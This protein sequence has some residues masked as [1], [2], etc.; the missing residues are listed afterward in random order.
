M[1]EKVNVSI[2]SSSPFHGINN[3]VEGLEYDD[4]PS[5]ISNELSSPK[6]QAPKNLFAAKTKVS[7]VSFNIDTVPSNNG[8][9]EE[10]EAVSSKRALDLMLG[11]SSSTVKN[12]KRKVIDDDSDDEEPIQVQKVVKIPSNPYTPNTGASKRVSSLFQTT[13]VNNNN[14]NGGL[15]NLG[16]TCYMNASLQAL[17]SLAPFLKQS[18]P[19]KTLTKLLQQ[20]KNNSG[21]VKEI[22]RLL[23]E[24]S[25]KFRGTRQQDA[26]EFMLEV[27]DRLVSTDGDKQDDNAPTTVDSSS[28]EG[29]ENYEPVTPSVNGS[30]N[31]NNNSATPQITPGAI[32]QSA[33]KKEEHKTVFDMTLKVTLVCENNKCGFKRS[34]QEGMR[35]LS[36]DIEENQSIN[37]CVAGYFDN[38]CVEVK[39]EQCGHDK[40]NK[41]IEIETQPE[42]FM[43]HLKRFRVDV[44]EQGGMDVRKGKERVKIG[45]GLDVTGF[46]VPC[47]IKKE[48]NIAEVESSVGSKKYDLKAVVRHIG[49]SGTSGHYVTD[50][51]GKGGE[52]FNFN[53]SKVE[54]REE[55]A[56]LED[57][58]TGR[59]AYLC[60]YERV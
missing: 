11:G 42:A 2:P 56:V 20:V 21:D 50:A 12:S 59:E 22:K 58:S 31:N 40:A 41:T 53:D 16:N 5:S 55:R 25:N 29:K 26:H 9:D 49:G 43:I 23:D 44:N 10:D 6:K 8:M 52:W 1:V 24:V 27:I 18:Y 45:R 28:N 60:V 4:V 15:K 46:C 14:M 47:E 37:E 34:M 30:S 39:C 57:E 7:R 35:D 19:N 33:L 36:V 51:I 54:R 32:P 13:T 17:I 48:D 38:S 3:A